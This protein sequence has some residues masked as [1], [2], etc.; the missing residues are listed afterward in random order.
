MEARYQLR[1]SPRTGCPGLPRLGNSSASLPEG[2]TRIAYAAW[3]RAA[4]HI[5]TVR[6]VDV[7]VTYKAVKYL[8]MR[9]VG[10]E[11]LVRVS[12]PLGVS[13]EEVRGFVEANADWLE[14]ARGKVMTRMHGPA[15][16]VDGGEVK[17]WGKRC[18]L[19][20]Q[21]A[22]R[23]NARLA[24]GVIHVEG[25]SEDARRRALDEL[26]RKELAPVAEEMIE[27][28]EPRVGRRVSRVRLRR[29]TSR[30]GGGT[31]THVQGADE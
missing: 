11:G 5:L 22:Q 4:T 29:M 17:L 19:R 28:W 7:A 30:W 24:G 25:P 20:V 16:L 21:E 15:P 3:V 2:Q 8:R 18:D 10:A 31:W 27:R 14:R 1:H 9:V 26:Y 6:D 23:P 12:A 13:L